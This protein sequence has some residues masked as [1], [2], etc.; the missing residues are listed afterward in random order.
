MAD[1]N[2]TNLSLVKPEVGASTDTWG[3]KIN[4]N[5]DTLDG[6]FKGDGT[7]TSVGLN[8][9]SGK[10][11]NVTGT[12]TLPA[13]ATIGGVQAVSTT[14]TQTLTNKTI[15]ADN[16]TISGIAASSFVLSNG[17]GNIDGSAAQKAI[18]SG[19]VVGTTDAQTLTN[20]T[21]S[22]GTAITDGTINGATIGATTASTGSFTTL[23]Y[24]STLTGGTGVVNLGSG[25]LVKDASGRLL[26]G[27]TAVQ[28]INGNDQP[29]IQQH[30]TDASTSGISTIRHQ[31]GIGGSWFVLGKTRGSAAGGVTAV[32]N[33]DFLGS[34]AWCGADGT[35]LNTAGANIAALVDG[36]VATGSVPG[37]LSFSTTAVG[38]TGPAERARIAADGSQS[39]VIP[40]GSTLY[41]EFKC[42]AWVNFNGETS[43]GTIRASGNVS[44][45][46]RNGTGDYTVNFTTAMPDAN[47]SFT[48]GGARDTSGN[49]CY[50][51]AYSNGVL[52]TSL[53][54]RGF[55][56]ST[57]TA[58]DMSYYTVAIFR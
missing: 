44:S 6:V 31:N 22:S 11:L 47:Y 24:N 40:G 26:R 42:R 54:V 34:I 33:G 21:L 25:Q 10:T 2:T 28:L 8:V 27:A 45:V 4:T 56:N 35:S 46:T 55:S 12:A 9:G 37:R 14:A 39:S 16:N 1:S 7:G 43:P 32:Q 57:V 5:L 52:T 58:R 17:S 19:V 29:Y 51:N 3:T 38:G 48:F 50:Y 53:R 20:K 23:A 41:P 15:S 18:P 49:E 30:G 13:A 36:A